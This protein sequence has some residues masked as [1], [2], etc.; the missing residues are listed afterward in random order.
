MN[1]KN[2]ETAAAVLWQAWQQGHSIDSL[3][4]DCRP[5]SLEQGYAVQAALAARCGQPVAGWKI[6]ATSTAGQTHI[7]VDGPLAGRLFADRISRHGSTIPLGPANIMC[8]AEAEFAFMLAEDLPPRPE[9]Y[10]Q[11]EVLARVADL[12]PAIEIPNSRFADFVHAG[13]AQLVA[14]DAC[15]HRFVLGEKVT[16]AWRRVNLASHPVTLYVNDQPVT[17]GLG[18]DALGDPRVALTWI[19]NNHALQGAGL[20]AG[21]I[22]TTGV[23]GKPSPI[24]AGDGVVADFGDFGRVT[25]TIERESL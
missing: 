4:A 11:E 1:S 25:V 15:A 19:A 24:E 6:A 14:D 2:I 20:V 7:A 16:A 9:P 17:R 8:V 21:Q 10:S 12:Y 3:P 5:Q 22:I 23:C 18:A 13:G